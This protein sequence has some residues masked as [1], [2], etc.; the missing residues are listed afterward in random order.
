M[1]TLEII[2]TAIIAVT[3]VMSLIVAIVVARRNKDKD[4]KDDGINMGKLLTEVSYI[5]EGIDELKESNRI[6]NGKIDNLST[7]VTKVETLIE[8]HIKDRHIHNYGTKRSVKK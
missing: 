2:W 8:D 7:R 6:E 3:P 1:T 4:T 5:H